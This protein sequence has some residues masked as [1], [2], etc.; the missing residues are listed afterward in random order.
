MA[1]SIQDTHKAPGGT[2][3]D[4][5][6]DFLL[7]GDF[8][9]RSPSA[10]NR[11]SVRFFAAA[12]DAVFARATRSARVMVSRLRLPPFAP[13][14]AIACRIKSRDNL[15]M[16]RSYRPYRLDGILKHN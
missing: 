11:F 13:I 14:W 2:P 4:N 6:L 1:A 5:Y 3:L 9:A 16:L 8:F 15:L 10:L 12:R 7:V